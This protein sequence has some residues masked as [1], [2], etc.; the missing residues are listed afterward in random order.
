MDVNDNPP[1]AIEADV[2]VSAPAAGAG[3]PDVEIRYHLTEQVDTL[4]QAILALD[5]PTDATAAQDPSEPGSMLSSAHM[6]TYAQ[7]FSISTGAGPVPMGGELP[8]PNP[9]SFAVTPSSATTSQQDII[10]SFGASKTPVER[11]TGQISSADVG[12]VRPRVAS[13]QNASSGDRRRSISDRASS[14][15]LVA[16][17]SRKGSVDSMWVDALSTLPVREISRQSSGDFV[18]V[19]YEYERQGTSMLVQ[20]L[21][22]TEVF[23]KVTENSLV[24]RRRLSNVKTR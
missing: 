23:T 7:T 15:I 8:P 2:E 10:P 12:R 24:V 9:S 11:V 22:E 14:G 13:Y 18:R 4:E 21:T 3:S 17:I 16:V 6:N 5:F 20:T 1:I 19:R